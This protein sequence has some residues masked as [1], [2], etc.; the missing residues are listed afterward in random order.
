LIDIPVE[1]TVPKNTSDAM[2]L[3]TTA[4]GFAE[5]LRGSSYTTNMD[6]NQLVSLLKPTLEQDR[7]GY[8]QELL[9]LLK[10]ADAL[11]Q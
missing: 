2:L 1:N 3:A 9:Q 5:T 7:W 6:Y 10:N 11:T 4:A 8:R